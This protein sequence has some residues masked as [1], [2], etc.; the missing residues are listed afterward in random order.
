VKKVR[1]SIFPPRC[2]DKFRSTVRWWLRAASKSGIDNWAKDVVDDEAV[3]DGLLEL[4]CRHKILAKELL[5]FLQQLRSVHV[6]ARALRGKARQLGKEWKEVERRAR[7]A[8]GASETY[9]GDLG[10]RAVEVE[11]AARLLSRFFSEPR[12]KRPMEMEIADSKESIVAFLKSRGVRSVNQYGWIFLRAVFGKHWTAGSGRDQIEAF[13]AIPKPFR[14]RIK[15]RKDVEIVMGR[16][17]LAVLKMELE[18]KKSS[19]KH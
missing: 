14:G 4:V 17:K 7:K 2:L 1:N 8:R 9:L 6:P 11:N 3:M 13:R 15:D 10:H 19:I 18:A 5:G 12:A 16:A